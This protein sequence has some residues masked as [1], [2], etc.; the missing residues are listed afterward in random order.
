MKICEY[1]VFGSVDKTRDNLDAIM[2][3]STSYKAQFLTV[4]NHR[5][6]EIIVLFLIC[7]YGT[8]H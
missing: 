6:A 5:A 1:I 3:K 4:A 7:C 8:N 2:D